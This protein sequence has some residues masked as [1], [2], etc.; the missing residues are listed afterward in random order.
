V[1]PAQ[2][3]TLWEKWDKPEI[4]WY[5]GGHV[6]VYEREREW[7]AEKAFLERQLAKLDN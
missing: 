6:L 2:E 7:K 1:P 4:Y 3:L 5:P